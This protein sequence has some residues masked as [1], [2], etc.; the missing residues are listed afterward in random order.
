[1]AT[2]TRNTARES[3]SPAVAENLERER[4]FDLFRQ[5]GY[6]EAD[7]DPLGLMTPDAFPDLQIENEWAEE[8]RRV[9]CGS[10]GAE[11]MHIADPER[12]RWIQESQEGDAGNRDQDMALDL[13]NACYP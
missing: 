7:L 10:V 9:Y 8:A 2:S 6:L 3:A 1:M 4:T 5:W 12:R 11:F 13:L